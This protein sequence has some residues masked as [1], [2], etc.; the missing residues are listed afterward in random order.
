MVRLSLCYPVYRRPDL[1]AG[2]LNAIIQSGCKDDVEVL[3]CDDSTERLNER[4]V[5]QARNWGL[6]IR[7]VDNE[8]N[9]G[10]DA[11]IKQC[12]DLA[13]T[14]Y[15]W[16]LGEDDHVTADG[17]SAVLGAIAETSSSIYFADYVYCSNDY[18]RWL[19]KPLFAGLTVDS[20]ESMLARFHRI[21]FV[22]S[23]VIRHDLWTRVSP[24][25]PLGT[26]YHHVSVVGYSIF[27]LTAS[28]GYVDKICVLNR[29]EDGKSA[30][31][32]QQALA[33]HFGYYRAIKFFEPYLS[34]AQR[35]L[36]HSSSKELFRPHSVAW[37]LSKRADG[38]FSSGDIDKWY[39]DQPAL[40]Q[41]LYRMVAVT[42][43]RIASLM[44]DAYALRKRIA[45]R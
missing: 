4:V 44:K 25:A 12:F 28:V 6:T 23:I 11:N 35:D 24:Q 41:L 15:C 34:A 3:V 1:L 22:G 8:R 7:Y 13:R 17:L 26:Y 38:A 31:W 19:S 37:L 42:P 45:A 14:E 30:S 27:A 21:G 20:Q 10:I 40:R 36:L 2:A 33:V 43:R 29:A 32:V 16:V 39:A 9:L 5:E 18:S